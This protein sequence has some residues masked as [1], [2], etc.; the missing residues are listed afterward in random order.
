MGRI[1]SEHF[2]VVGQ[3]AVI[4]SGEIEPH[5]PA[6]SRFQQ[7][8]WVALGCLLRVRGPVEETDHDVN[9]GLVVP[10]DRVIPSLWRV[11][12]QRSHFGNGSAI[13]PKYKDTVHDRKQPRGVNRA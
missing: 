9:Y 2:G 13:D 10:G 12:T 7:L 4:A 3:G 6:A 8:P 1:Q 5:P 11:E